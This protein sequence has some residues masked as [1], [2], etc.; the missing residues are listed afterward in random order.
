MAGA[1]LF[2]PRQEAAGLNFSFKQ[3]ADISRLASSPIV[4]LSCAIKPASVKDG[5]QF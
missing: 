2:P 1:A 3:H 5:L 4:L